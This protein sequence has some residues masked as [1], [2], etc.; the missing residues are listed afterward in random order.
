MTST[1]GRCD[2]EK[3]SCVTTFAVMV[4][5][6][7]SAVISHVSSVTALWYAHFTVPP[8]PRRTIRLFID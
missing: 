5:P 6:D 3:V 8:D 1:K 7:G 4:Q 2:A